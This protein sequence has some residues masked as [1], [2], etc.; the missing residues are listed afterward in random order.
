[1]SKLL[2]V[3][4]SADLL[5][6]MELILEQK[7]YTVK[8]LAGSNNIFTELDAFEPDLLILDIF[9]AGYDGR[10]ICKELRKIL[11][12]K[13]LCIIMF[14][15]SPKALE[16][17]KSYGADDCLEKPFGI[18]NLVDKIESV[19]ARCNVKSNN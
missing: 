6:A 17:Y 14:S 19:L 7:G 8:T 10:Q 5:E 4:D 12:N 16:D 1:M 3:D 2:I 18:N 11:Q 15:A 13:Y 9:L